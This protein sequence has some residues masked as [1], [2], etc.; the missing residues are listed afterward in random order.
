[1]K[2]HF[3]KANSALRRLGITYWIDCGT[4]LGYVREDG[5][6]AHDPDFDFGTVNWPRHVEIGDA[7]QAKGFEMTTTGFPEYGYEQSFFIEGDHLFDIFYFYPAGLNRLW[8]GSWHQGN[9]LWS[10]FDLDA[11]LPVKEA[12]FA[13][14]RTFIPA[15]PKKVLKTRYGRRWRTP[16]TT[17]NYVTDPYCFLEARF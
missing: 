2:K 4:L 9:V 16:V 11:Y 12:T 17:W 14:V 15:N 5:F 6:L 1:M 8:Q 10:E 3:R 7:P 13:G